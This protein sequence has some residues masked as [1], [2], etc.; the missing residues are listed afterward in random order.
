MAIDQGHRQGRSEEG[1][2]DVGVAVAIAPAQ[3]VPVVDVWRRDAVEQLLQIVN[4]AGLVL[5]GRQG[6]GG[7]GGKEG[8]DAI[9]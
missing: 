1:M 7:A 5:E 8:D 9:P 3:V 6:A 2:P 4:R